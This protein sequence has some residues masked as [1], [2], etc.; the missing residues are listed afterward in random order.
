MSEVVLGASQ[1]RTTVSEDYQTAAAGASIG[2]NN[3]GCENTLGPATKYVNTITTDANGVITVT[4]AS[5]SADLD[6]AAG[7]TLT[8][9]PYKDNSTAATA[10]DI[11]LQIYKFVCKGNSAGILKYLP[12]SCR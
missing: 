9:T 1:C 11:P 3:W 5:N 2:A 6:I 12:G 7:Q 8:M 4:A 10:A